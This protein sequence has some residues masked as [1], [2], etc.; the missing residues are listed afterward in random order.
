MRHKDLGAT[1]I[2]VIT[3]HQYWIYSEV[4][5]FFT[6]SILKIISPISFE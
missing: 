2:I 5:A 6:L 1:I 3:I 4:L